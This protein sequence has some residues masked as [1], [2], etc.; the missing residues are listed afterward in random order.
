M[1]LEQIAV[2]PKLQR[3]GIGR[4]LILESL[5]IVQRYLEDRQSSLKHCIVTTRSDN[6]AQNLY[7]TTLGAEVEA[8]LCNLYSA[9]ELIMI[10]RNVSGRL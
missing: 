8:T 1:E 9:D 7:R 5:G 2:L 4:K 6:S 3:K 10:A